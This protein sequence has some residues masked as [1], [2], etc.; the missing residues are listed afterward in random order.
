MRQLNPYLSFNGQAEEAFN[1]Y[2]SV[3]GGELTMMRW[4]DN[5]HSADFSDEEKKGVMH[6]SLP[7]GDSVIIGSDWIESMGELARGTNFQVAVFPESRDDADRL[8]AGLSEG[9]KVMMPMA[10]QFWGD[11]F[12]SFTDKFG[13]QWMIDY[14]ANGKNQERQN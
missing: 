7:V 3:F 13:I 12:G 4:G 9:G 11:Y 8:F 2:R 6:V 10:D 14:D 5:P 1:F